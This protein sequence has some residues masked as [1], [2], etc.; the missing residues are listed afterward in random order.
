MDHRGGRE[1]DHGV[2]EQKTGRRKY[3]TIR[4]YPSPVLQTKK[5]GGLHINHSPVEGDAS[6]HPRVPPQVE[7]HW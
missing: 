5:A 3:L 2:G 4:T 6:S 7:H 1:K